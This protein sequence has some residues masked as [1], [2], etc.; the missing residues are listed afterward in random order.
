MRTANSRTKKDRLLIVGWDGA[1]W[2]VLD[3]LMRDGYMPTLRS[4]TQEGL[5]G[6]LASTIPSHSWAAWSSFLTGVNPGRH[7]VYDFVEVDP[8]DP[9]RRIP[10]SSHS[11]KASTF[12]EHLSA[13][14]HE[15][16]IG[17][18]PV[19]F[20][21]FPVRGRLI[22]GV[23]IP[24]GAGFVYPSEWSDAL[25]RSAPFPVNGMEWTAFRER[26]QDLVAEAGRLESLRTESFLRMLDGNWSVATC[27]YVAPDRLQH[28]F[29]R[30][31]MATHPD[32]P[33]L[34]QTPLAESLRDMYR[35]LD[36]H[37]ERLRAAAGHNATTIVMSDHGFRP[38]T[39]R[40]NPNALLAE[41]GFQS[42]MPGADAKTALLKSTVGRAVARTRLGRIA[43]QRVRAPSVV[44]WP[45]TI[46]YQS[47]TGFGVSVNLSGREP[48]GVVSRADYDATREEVRAALLAF[49]DPET[50]E[51][52]VG[53]VWRREELYSGSAA[54][55]APDLIIEW[56]KLW[57]YQDTGG[58]SNR[59]DWPSGDHRREGILVAAGGRTIGGKIGVRDI[60]DISA[61]ALAFCGIS[62]S[63]LDGRPI[64]EIAGDRAG[65]E[66]LQP[67]ERETVRL[68][69]EDEDSITE[70]LRGLGYI[71]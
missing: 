11:I 15:V 8:K 9:R 4:M 54:T 7:G 71:D 67:A 17:N 16:R 42:M 41:L 34:A 2:D 1:D 61:T 32:H 55:L 3:P 25:K 45:R 21:P 40:V 31:L 30:Y 29:A 24:P 58:L 6:D 36:R 68:R 52:P 47:G 65:A 51:A 37:L 66:L 20:P 28:P 14:G 13:A 27:V 19:T 53:N 56:N 57:D 10:I 48:K 39:R 23:A 64:S 46:A 38:V 50:E 62:P 44:D 35:S 26:P 59:V 70:H 5:R 33:R 18:V 22:S 12:F 49:R 60:A 43:K 69:D 63:A